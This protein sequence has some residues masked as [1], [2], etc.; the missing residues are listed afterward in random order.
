M[1]D[2]GAIYTVAPGEVLEDLGIQPLSEEIFWLANGEKLTRK[3]G[4][5]YFR[6]GDR[7][8]G[9][10]VVF[11]EEGDANLLGATTLESLG[12]ALDPLKRELK[13]MRL[14]IGGFRPYR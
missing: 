9:A 7:V 13:P 8:G 5:G 1:V 10:D 3:R 6:Y 2:S 4:I 12:L 14:I 11:G